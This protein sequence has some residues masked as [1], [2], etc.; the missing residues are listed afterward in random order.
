MDLGTLIA[1]ALLSLGIIGS[2]AVL[3]AD[4]IS[5]RIEVSKDLAEAGYSTQLVD[6]MMDS[7][8]K[9]LVD[10]RSIVSQ[11]EIRSA[12]EKTIVGAVADSV[13]LREIT[14]AFQNEFGL[15]QVHLTGALMGKEGEFRF[16]M[17]GNSPHTGKFVLDLHSKPQETLPVFLRDVALDVVGRIEPYAAAIADFNNRRASFATDPAAYTQFRAHCEQILADETKERDAANDHASFHNLMGMAAMLSADN[18][19]ATAQFER[20]VA[21]DP[22]LGVPAIN[23]ALLNLTARRFDDAIR[24]AEAASTTPFVK[25][26]GFLLANTETIAGLAKWGKKDLPGAQEE[27]V[28]SVK[29]YPG[30][31]WGYYYWSELQR[32]AGTPEDAAFLRERADRTITTFETYPEVAFIY[33]R[34]DPLKDFTFAH[35]DINSA[36]R[37][38]DIEAQ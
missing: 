14:G 21:L 22:T 12:E 15:S 19:E 35:I 31:F 30:S 32:V 5:F 24:Y 9:E 33:M 37:V 38:S 4:N 17:S 23:L 29:A 26:K 10:F 11:P 3:N 8:M 20:A 36:H 25:S 34:I 16:L 28:A 6:A 7:A 27:F 13:N 18:A 2:D 1:A